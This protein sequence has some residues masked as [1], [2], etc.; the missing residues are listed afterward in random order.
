MSAIYLAELSH[1]DLL[2]YVREVEKENKEL[3]I[4]LTEHLE[5][6]PSEDFDRG[7]EACK[8]DTLDEIDTV[9]AE[10]KEL[11]ERL[12]TLARGVEVWRQELIVK[13]TE[14]SKTWEKEAWIR[15]R[16]SQVKEWETLKE[17]VREAVGEEHWD[18]DIVEVCEQ[19]V[20]KIEVLEELLEDTGAVFEEDEDGDI[21]V[22]S[23]VEAEL[24]SGEVIV[25]A[26][27][28]EG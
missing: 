20:H 10:N 28:L 4:R 9:G 22:V 19:L 7:Y 18:G 21:V 23:P 3:T 11:K 8:N 13:T 15:G 6:D 25:E 26:E 1:E 27:L 24:V 17:E 5:E 16:N 14:A 12:E 2:L